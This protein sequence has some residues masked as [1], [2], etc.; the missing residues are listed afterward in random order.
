[1]ATILIVDDHPVNREFLV[2]LLGYGGHRLLQAADGA[3]ALVLARAEHPDLIIADILMPT[4]DGYEL[5]RQL[6]ADAAIAQTPVIFCTAHYLE[7]EARTLAQQCGVAHHS[8]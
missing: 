5:V 2:T 8:Y 4:M 6:R 3:E 1:M 7:H